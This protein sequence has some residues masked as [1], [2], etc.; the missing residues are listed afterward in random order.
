MREVIEMT[1]ADWKAEG[2]KKFGP[3]Y[4]K[5]QFICPVCGHVASVR[6]YRAVGAV[7]GEIGFS[8]IGRRIERS[9][10]AFFERGNGPCDYTGGG[11]F[12]LNPVKIQMPNG[13]IIAAFKFAP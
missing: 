4:L 6:D 11:L 13:K 12:G 10:S 1:Y 3:D 5:W 9:R 2:E 8:C 7:D